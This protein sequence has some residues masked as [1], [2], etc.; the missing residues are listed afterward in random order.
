MLFLR[1]T[2]NELFGK[3]NPQTTKLRFIEQIIG[4]V[5]SVYWGH[6]PIENFE[7]YTTYLDFNLLENI[8]I[9]CLDEINSIM[10]NWQQLPIG[11]HL[12]LEWK[13]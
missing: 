3:D 11:G 6:I 2:F 8:L 10:E 1:H 12:M 7:E 9:I 5:Q 13:I 4:P